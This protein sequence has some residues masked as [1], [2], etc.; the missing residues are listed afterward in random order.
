MKR[1]VVVFSGGQDSTTCL[2]QALRQYDEVHCVT[3]DYG[4]RHRAE[5]DVASRISKELGAA[6]HKVLDVTLLNE[7][8]ISSLT[9]DNIPVPDFNASEKSDLPNTFVPGRNILFL[10]LAAIY[11]YQVE[12]EAVITGVCETDFSGYPDC[13]DE[14]V[15]ALNKAVSLGIARDIRFETPLMWLNKAE[16]WALADYYKKLDFIRNQTLTCYNGIQGDG[17]SECAACHLR[18]KGLT[19]YLDNSQSI[20]AEMKSKT[21]L[22]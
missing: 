1:A 9:R 7:L 3:F 17:C 6:A 12:A 20:M 4:Q 10:T 5:I 11:A 2:I 16:T 18:A 8:A 22:S 19:N 14:F 21:H 15:R 13:R